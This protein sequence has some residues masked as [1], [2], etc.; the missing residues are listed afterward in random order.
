M[1]KHTKGLMIAGSVLYI[2]AAVT[3]ALSGKNITIW[4]IAFMLM[5]AAALV[6]GN[7]AL[8]AKKIGNLAV[9]E[10]IRVEED[11]RILKDT[12][13]NVHGLKVEIE[14]LNTSEVKENQ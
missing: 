11:N 7:S 14:R 1:C 9:D 2:A 13:E 6:Y 4:L 8:H 3:V 12:L 10:L 5:T